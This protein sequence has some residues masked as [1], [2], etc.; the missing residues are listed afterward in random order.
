MSRLPHHTVDD[1]PPE[2]RELLGEMS[3]VSPTG[4]PLNLHAELAGAPAVLHAYVALRRAPEQYGGL[5]P[6]TRVG[7]MLAAAG[8]VDNAYTLVIVSMLAGRVGWSDADIAAIRVGAGVGDERFDVLARVVR[9][10][11]ID[12][13]RV[14]EHTWRSALDAGWES[15]ELAEAFSPLALVLYTAYFANYA[16][17]DLDS[18][19]TA[20]PVRS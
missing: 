12:A 1:A 13:G 10:A 2:S 4:Q 15:R 8:A 18:A 9:E 20:V 17:T 14:D 5:E 19:L 16:G 7:L 11:A 3:A 6:R